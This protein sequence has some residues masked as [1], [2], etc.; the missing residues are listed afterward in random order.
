[1]CLSVLCVFVSEEVSEAVVVVVAAGTGDGFDE[2]A[3]H[4]ILSRQSFESKRKV[5]T[6]N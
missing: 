3:V 4:P 2:E 5:A 1:M 6:K